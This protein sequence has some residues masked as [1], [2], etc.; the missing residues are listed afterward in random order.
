MDDSLLTQLK[1]MPLNML[2]KVKKFS[3][4]KKEF[5]PLKSF[6]QQDALA[7]QKGFIGRTYVAVNDSIRKDKCI[8]SSQFPYTVLGYI[9]LTCSEID[10]DGYGLSDCR[11]AGRYQFLPAVK[12]ARLA[13]DAKIRAAGIGS[14]LFQ[15]AIVI[16]ADYILPYVGCRFLITEAKR[17]S[18][19]FYH[20]KGMRLLDTEENH[21]STHPLMYMDL[22]TLLDS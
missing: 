22:V 1:I 16:A 14:I 2:H 19:D 3:G 10:F 17:E 15:Q 20:R 9:T 6:L 13:V 21:R 4:G 7:F 5:Q 12:I 18:I 11:R 8:P